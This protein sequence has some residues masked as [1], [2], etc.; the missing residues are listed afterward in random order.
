MIQQVTCVK[1]INQAM[2]LSLEPRD[3]IV[4]D[5]PE[6]AVADMSSIIGDYVI[7]TFTIV[8]MQKN[9]KSRLKHWSGTISHLKK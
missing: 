5:N 6:S 8:K 4:I 7:V 9:G 1:L 2:S 3:R